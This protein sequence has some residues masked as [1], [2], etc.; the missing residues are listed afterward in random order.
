M[1]DQTMYTITDSGL[2][3]VGKI[4]G[5]ESSDKILLFSH[6]FGVDSNSSGMFS[7][8][9]EMFKD[10]FLT[11]R[12]HYVS[13]DD[14]TGNTYVHPF[15][16]Q[17]E[18][19]SSIVE[20]IKEKYPEKGIYVISHSQGCFIS[21][22]YQQ[23]RREKRLEKFI[24]LSPPASTNLTKKMITYFSKKS[25]SK[26]DL[27][28]ISVLERSQGN[29]TY[30]PKSFWDEADKLDPLS[31]YRFMDKNF[32]C[33]FVIAENDTVLDRSEQDSLTAMKPKHFY[34]LPNDHNY[35]EDNMLGLMELMSRLLS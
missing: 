14:F 12:F 30:V 5:N 19:F 8:L 34:R 24:F 2:Q 28:G 31:L 23:S 3:I 17:L 4:L 20:K 9:S 26:V 29:K 15:S 10:K 16:I 22:M 33:H 27:G 13:T 18:K 1:L 7:L 6:G 25:N 21:S 35:K 32:D 11:V